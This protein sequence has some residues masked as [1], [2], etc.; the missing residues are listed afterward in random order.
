M[1]GFVVCTL[2]GL[3][4][5]IMGYLIH[6]KKQ[7]FLIAGYQDATFIGDKNKLAKLFGI[8][9]YIVGIATF[10][11]PIGLEF[12]GGISGKI[13]ATCVVVGTA[14]VLVRKQMLNKPF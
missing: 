5:V 3:I 8:F 1:S 13:Y 9:A 12:F 7:L 6:I 10:L 14:F 11:L 2:V 4:I